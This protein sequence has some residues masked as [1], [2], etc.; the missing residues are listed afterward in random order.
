MRK[1]RTRIRSGFEDKSLLPVR[2]TRTRTRSC[3]EDKILLPVRKT[4]TRT[5]SDFEDKSLLPVEPELVLAEACSRP[6]FFELKS[7]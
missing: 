2:E 3:F 1:T 4:R 7:K 5:R 6:S